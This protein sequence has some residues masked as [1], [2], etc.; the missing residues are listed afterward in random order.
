M[1]RHLSLLLLTLVLTG[2]TACARQGSVGFALTAAPIAGEL[3]PQ[4]AAQAQP[5]FVQVEGADLAARLAEAQRRARSSSPQTPYWTAYAFD[6]RPGVAVDPDVRE[7]HGSM[8]TSGGT[9][10]FVG[11]H[12]GMTVETRNLAVFLLREAGGAAVTRLEVYNLERRREYG[13]YPVYFAGRA[14]NEES[15]SYLRAVVEG[16][17]AP[18]D[19]Y[20]PAL[21]AEHATLAIALHDDPRVAATLKQLLRSSQ[22][23]KVRATSVYWLGQIGGETEFLAEIVR[24]AGERQEV[25]K[26]A[27]HAIGASRDRAAL[28]TL[29]S[30]YGAVAERE[31]RRAI[32][33]AVAENEDRDGALAFLLRVARTD[34]DREA[35]KHAVHRVGELGGDAAVE[36]LMKLYAAEQDRDARRAVLHA[37]SEIDSPRAQSRLVEI[38]RS[39][40]EPTDLRRQAIH[41]LGERAGEAGLDE[42]IRIFDAD[43]NPD[44]RRQI[45]HALS[46]MKGRRAEDKLF[47]VARKGDDKDLRR[48]AVHWIGERAGRRSLELLREMAESPSADTQ[49]QMQAVRAISERP[50]EEAVPLLIKI[51]R[52]HPSQQV[53]RAAIRQLG[54]SGDPR[55]VEFFREVLTTN[56]GEKQ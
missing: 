32:I 37:L 28:G 16:A 41:W 21:V 11:T 56:R 10:V 51:A 20:K 39:S 15:M 7:F 46:E 50:A 19:A 31:V 3:L 2:A 27:A 14:G 38:A 33:H 29:Q 6:V 24:N 47:E 44:I 52:T 4:R 13:G 42:L 23:P 55:A 30:L 45:L 9:S 5:G 49:I 48:Q 54:E 43:A 1:R 36:E 18:R 34:A 35:R 12:N 22:N 40:A 26:Q 25:R 17:P 8:N 53:R